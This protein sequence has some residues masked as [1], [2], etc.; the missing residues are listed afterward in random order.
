MKIQ[1]RFRKTPRRRP[2]IM[3]CTGQTKPNYSNQVGHNLELQ[4]KHPSMLKI[5]NNQ[6]HD[7][8]LNN[9]SLGMSEN[10]WNCTNPKLDTDSYVKAIDNC[11]SYHIL[12]NKS[13]F[14]GDMTPWK[15]INKGI[16][17]FNQVTECSTVS[18]TIKN[19]QRQ[20]TQDGYTLQP[21]RNW[22]HSIA[23]IATILGANIKQSSRH[24]L[25]NY[26]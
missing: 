9:A 23:F 11:C 24:H 5:N 17:G 16:G 18:W 20:T 8:M 14:K 21:T 25:P 26:A 19:D 3:S 22:S 15:F 1:G 2:K 12:N 10:Q 7:S 4:L 6:L 13:N